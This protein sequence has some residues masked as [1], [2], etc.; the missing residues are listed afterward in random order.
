MRT[1]LSSVYDPLDPGLSLPERLDALERWE[2]TWMEMDL[3]EPNAV[4]N[5]PVLAG[6]V[7]MPGRGFF[8]S[9]QYLI[10]SHERIGASA[11]YSFLD[12]HARSSHTK[13]AR[14]TTIEIDTTILAFAFASELNLAVAISCVNL[15]VSAHSFSS[16]TLINSHPTEQ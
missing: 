1:A 4:I 15:P 6:S 5:A 13:A 16:G 9:G 10:M 7:L 3:H 12:I 14:W 8:L 2:T 11:F